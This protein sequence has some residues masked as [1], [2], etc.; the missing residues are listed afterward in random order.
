MTQT[1]E[2]P[3]PGREHGPVEMSFPGRNDIQPNSP[4]QGPAQAISRDLRLVPPAPPPRPRRLEVQISVRDGRAPIG[5]SRP[6]R[7][8]HDDLDELIDAAIRME[9]RR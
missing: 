4:S 5:R 9:R 1:R 3:A 2:G 6:L 7:L 8:T